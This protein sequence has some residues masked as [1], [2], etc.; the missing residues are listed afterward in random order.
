[1][2][3]HQ[4]LA[5]CVASLALPLLTSCVRARAGNGARFREPSRIEVGTALAGLGGERRTFPFEAMA[6]EPLKLAPL[7][8]A[9]LD[10][11]ARET[12]CLLAA[13]ADVSERS[14]GCQWDTPLL[15]ALRSTL[16]TQRGPEVVR[17]LLTHGADPDDRDVE[18]TSCLELAA[19]MDRADLLQMLIEAGADVDAQNRSGE[20]AL[21]SCSRSPRCAEALARAGADL[22]LQSRGGATALLR[23][24]EAGSVDTVRVLLSHG[25]ALDI[26]Y[27]K[28]TILHVALGWPLP[29]SDEQM[30]SVAEALLRAGADINAV[31]AQG[32]S[33]LHLAAENGKAA[34]CRWLV[35]NG[36][37]LDLADDLL[38]TP[39]HLAAA[40]GRV[41]ATEVLLNAGADSDARDGSG[42]TALHWAAWN[43]EAACAKALLAGSQEPDPRDAIGATPLHLAAEACAYQTAEL[44]LEAGADVNARDA[45]GWTPLRLT[46][47]RVP[48]DARVEGMREL[49]KRHGAAMW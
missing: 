28:T 46:Y 3:T 25:A 1:V 34:F 39:L 7:D 15:L 11:D 19:Q 33:P 4:V 36:A 17:I 42:W 10:G 22:D 41:E 47:H 44:L 16:N 38:Q 24:V 37:R 21:F 12:E 48:L 20:T 2:R 18:G 43:D 5:I 8:S 32:R 29:Y 27:G 13:G 30:L 35:D 31:D 14:L 9:I 23:A 40:S 26:G 45:Y 49:L 6:G